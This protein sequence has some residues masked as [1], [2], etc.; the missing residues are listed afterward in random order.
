MTN[1]GESSG[2][3][4]SGEDRTV[5]IVIGGVKRQDDPQMARFY[6]FVTAPDD[7]GAVRRCLEALA[8]EGFEEADLDQIG[9]LTGP[10]E[11][12]EFA[13]PYAAALSGEVALMIFDS[14]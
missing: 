3:V 13:D 4:D 14:E 10:P 8:S 1:S 11:E 7:D 12:E 2:T 9:I 5:F 6:A